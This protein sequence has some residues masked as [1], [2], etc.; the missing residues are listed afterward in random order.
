MIEQHHDEKGCLWTDATTPFKFDV[1]ISSIK[2]EEQVAFATALYE[3]MK[4]ANISVLLDDRNE[5]FGFKMGDFELLG[6]PYAII[7][8]KGLKMGEVQLVNRRTLEK[9]TIKKDEIFER[10]KGL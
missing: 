8:G 6:F 4:S 9:E 2:D 3:E 7:V 1:V 10:I 5:R